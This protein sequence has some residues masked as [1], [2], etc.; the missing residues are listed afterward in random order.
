MIQKTRR[1]GITGHEMLAIRFLGNG[2]CGQPVRTL[3]HF[4][5]L[6]S[7]FKC[8]N[9]LASQ[10]E[11]KNFYSDRAPDRDCDDHY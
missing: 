2:Q 5:L 7:L 10:G 4:S 9:V 3:S 1:R 11:N 6:P 8:S